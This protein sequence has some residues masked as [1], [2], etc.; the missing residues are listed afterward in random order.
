M[1]VVPCSTS[2]G[3]RTPTSSGRLLKSRTVKR[4]GSQNIGIWEPQRCCSR[5]RECKCIRRCRQRGSNRSQLTRSAC[6]P[7]VGHYT[8]FPLGARCCSGFS[9]S[10]EP[11]N[12]LSVGGDIGLS[13]SAESDEE[14]HVVWADLRPTHPLSW[15]WRNQ[16]SLQRGVESVASRVQESR[17]AAMRRSWK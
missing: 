7:A 17:S 10:S 9:R 4:T 12:I 14:D 2:C 6:R 16:L 11:E 5:L 3:I 13:W 1:A 8:L 15:R